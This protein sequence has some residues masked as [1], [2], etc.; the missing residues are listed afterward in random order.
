[1]IYYNF[2]MDKRQRLR[3]LTVNQILEILSRKPNAIPSELKLSTDLKV[4][5]TVVR[6]AFEYLQDKGI[7][8]KLGR[9]RLQKR[10]IQQDDYIILDQDDQSSEEFVQSFFLSQ[11]KKG[12]IRP[13]TR[14]SVLELAKVSGCDRT[15]VREFLNRF[16][17][18]GLV[19]KLPRR[20]W[21]LVSID[22][23]YIN[24]LI[25]ARKDLELEALEY[26]LLLPST[27]P[28]WLDIKNIRRK[29]TD[30][31]NHIYARPESIQELDSEFFK[32]FIG[33]F[34]N[35][36][37]NQYYDTIY[38]ICKL[39][40]EWCLDDE[41]DQAMARL[42]QLTEFI[43]KLLERQQEECIDLLSN[44]LES[45]RQLFMEALVMLDFP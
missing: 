19:E 16:S 4:S 8:E 7:V 12:E 23:S 14:F 13:G 15:A 39:L 21:G 10:P 31:H 41:E 43:D 3:L 9:N 45:T 36:F 37:K 44:H 20:M 40:Y 6:N 28:I 18:F 35:R 33:S 17:R 34:S 1:M 30:F 2:K 42:V 24:E 26:L 29:I 25:K 27:A 32:V 5:R 11:L 22:K 38:F